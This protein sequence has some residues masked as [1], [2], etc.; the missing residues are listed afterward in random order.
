[1]DQSGASGKAKLSG[2][3]PWLRSSGPKSPEVRAAV[4]CNAWKG[5]HWLMVRQAVKGLNEALREQRDQLGR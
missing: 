2:W 4:A 3:K 5:G 1:M